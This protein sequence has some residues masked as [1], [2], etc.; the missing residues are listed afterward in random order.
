MIITK[1]PVQFCILLSSIISMNILK[2]S[3]S[4]LMNNTKLRKTYFNSV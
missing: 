2:G 4:T 1:Y 3:L